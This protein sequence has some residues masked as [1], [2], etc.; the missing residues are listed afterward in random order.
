MGSGGSLLA[1]YL[2]KSGVKDFIFI[3]DDQLET[4]N[5]I[6]HIC[7]L[8]QIGRFKTKAVKDYIEFRVPEVS[9]TTVEKNS[10]YIRKL[11]L[12]SI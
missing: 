2:S 9:I 11:M 6:R 7:D 3:D 5:I 4:H 8:T 10:L 1:V 12:I